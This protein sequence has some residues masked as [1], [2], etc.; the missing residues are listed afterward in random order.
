MF[1]IY[2]T[3]LALFVVA[4]HIYGVPGVGGY[5]VHAFFCLSGFLMTLLVCE[6]YKGRPLDFASN[7]FLRLYPAYWATATA[8]ALL[9]LLTPIPEMIGQGGTWGWG[10]PIKLSDILRNIAFVNANTHIEL[11]PVSWAVTNEL[12]FYVLIGLGITNTPL[13][14]FICL[15][16]SIL[17]TV[18]YWNSD[19]FGAPGTF[20][21]LPVSAAPSFAVGAA[22][23]HLQRTPKFQSFMASPTFP[24]V[25]I[26]LAL[27][28]GYF[29]KVFGQTGMLPLYVNMLA[30]APLIVL[31][32]R[33]NSK[34]LAPLD[35]A[36]GRFSY[37]IY[38]SHELAVL[39]LAPHP[40]FW[41]NAPWFR[42]AIV[43]TTLIIAALIVYGIDAPIER[44]RRKIRDKRTLQS[45]ASRPV[46]AD[47]FIGDRR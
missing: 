16:I 6:T 46:H 26:V 13:R 29:R 36:I 4:Q 38:L 24:I 39:I 8:T 42:S 34:T 47:A 31:L 20:Y 41:I 18:P 33:L 37:P 45:S 11:V 30:T 40:P 43:A 22:L 35:T 5:A 3:T 27:G 2:R 28:S 19:A 7:R 15:P 44:L 21:F 1:G 32:Y 23:Y 25:A 9:I 17:S 14:A 12:A 10:L